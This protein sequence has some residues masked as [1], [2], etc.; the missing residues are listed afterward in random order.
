MIQPNCLHTT[1]DRIAEVRNGVEELVCTMYAERCLN[2]STVLRYTMDTLT[3]C[4]PDGTEE[5]R[6]HSMR[7]RLAELESGR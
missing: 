5:V 4:Y 1:C 6:A 7:D 2:C 3:L